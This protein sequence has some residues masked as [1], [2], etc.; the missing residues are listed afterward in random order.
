MKK[1]MLLPVLLSLSAFTC[2]ER[3]EPVVHQHLIYCVTPEQYAQL[4]DAKPKQMS[5]S[6]L[7]GQAQE[8]FITSTR[9]GILLRI[10]ADGLL[11]V[12]GGCIGP[13]PSDA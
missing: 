6:D 7:T 3:P 10:Y 5:K 9:Q 8:D 13:S 1:L 12:L 2:Q 11:K 4:V